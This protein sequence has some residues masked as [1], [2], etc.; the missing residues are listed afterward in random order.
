MTVSTVTRSASAKY[1]TLERL[2]FV[3]SRGLA[4][5]VQKTWGD[6]NVVLGSEERRDF[7]ISG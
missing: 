6:P 1:S 7:V 5:F 2:G 4:P 3:E